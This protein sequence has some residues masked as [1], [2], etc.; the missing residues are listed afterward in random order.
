MIVS[1]E[2]QA[3]S[4][5]F[6]VGRVVNA[7]FQEKAGEHAVYALVA[8]KGGTF[9]YQPSA[10]AFDVVIHNSNT[11]LLLE[12]LRLLD[13]ANRDM[14]E[15]ETV[16]DDEAE[17]PVQGASQKPIESRAQP[18]AARMPSMAA[19]PVLQAI[20]DQNPLEEV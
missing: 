2:G 11:N 15:A 10:T 1:S 5:F 14:N 6:N 20:D 18:A 9:E 7:I 12:G 4:I 16:P 19:V 13:E 17:V 8:V 3:G